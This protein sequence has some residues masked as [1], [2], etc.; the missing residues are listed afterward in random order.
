MIIIKTT[1]NNPSIKKKIINKLIVNKYAACVNVIEKV[2]SNY[3]W[4][5]KIICDMEDILL[6]KTTKNK[7]KLVYKTIKEL[8]NY[9]IPEISTINTSKVEKEYLKWLANITR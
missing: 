2:N 3:I 8:H 9:D 4:D 6:I 5:N 1:V 7:E